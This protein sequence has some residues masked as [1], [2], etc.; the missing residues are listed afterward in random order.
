MVRASLSIPTRFGAS[1]GG[2][3]D[4]AEIVQ[5]QQWLIKNKAL[6]DKATMAMPQ[7]SSLGLEIQAMP[8]FQIS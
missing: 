4:P 8:G 1:L 3:E 2:F 7:P 5:L 6:K